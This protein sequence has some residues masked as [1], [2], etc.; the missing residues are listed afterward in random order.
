M[1]MSMIVKARVT[2]TI[3]QGLLAKVDRAARQR[4]GASRSSVI[5]EWLRSAAE[6]DAR[7]ALDQAIAEYYEGMSA[8]ERA[9]DAEWAHFSTRSFAVRESKAKYSRSRPRKKRGTT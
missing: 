6:Q 9:E 4:P 3:S 1:M 2:V 7:R 8:G 5:E